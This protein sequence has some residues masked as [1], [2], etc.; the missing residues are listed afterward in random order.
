MRVNNLFNRVILQYVFKHSPKCIIKLHETFIK[1]LARVVWN[2]SVNY[3]R[4]LYLFLKCTQ[5]AADVFYSETLK[6]VTC[7]L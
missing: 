1:S 7:I 5:L 4:K 3:K 2:I 6:I